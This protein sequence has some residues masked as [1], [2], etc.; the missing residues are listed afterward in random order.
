MNSRERISAAVNRKPVDKMAIDF[1][2]TGTTGVSVFVYRDA[3]EKL[4]IIGETLYLDEPLSAICRVEAEM[5][6]ALGGDVVCIYRQT[7]CLGM[8]VRDFALGNLID[9]TK[10]YIPT[11]F[12][13][14]PNEKGDMIYYKPSDGS[15]LLHPYLK[16]AGKN[17]DAGVPVAISPKGQKS[18]S[19]KYHPL[20]GVET[21]EELKKWEFPTTDDEELK[22]ITENAKYYYENT[23]KALC[24]V[25]NGNIFELGQL[26]WGYEDFFINLMTNDEM[27]DYYFEKRVEGLL[28][29]LDRYLNAFGKYI[30]LIEFTED[31]GSQTSLLISA[32]LYREKVKPYHKRMFDYIHKNY[33]DVKILLHSC[34]AV[35]EVIPDFIEIGVDALNPVQIS[36]K[37]MEPE[38]LVREFGKDICFYGGGVDTQST[39]CIKIPEEVKAEVLKNIEIFAKADGYVFTQV[40]NVED[41]VPGEN[42]L[43]AFLTAKDRR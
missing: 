2:G 14:K 12:N 24:F 15:D 30:Q 29:D 18:Y 27:M 21:L 13:P 25:F 34:G 19:R 5:R 7:P 32:D 17:H 22:Y 38:K 8:R 33:P 20:T 6:D 9:G 23:D 3:R 43:S 16:S 4:G 31:L 40:H 42:L 36:A 41:S 1:G 39:L 11:C 37:G 10:A 35:S 26:Y 28:Y